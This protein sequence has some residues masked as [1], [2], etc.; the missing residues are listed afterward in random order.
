MTT[1]AAAPPPVACETV[2][3]TLRVRDLAASLA[4][5]VDRLGFRLGFTW[6]DPPDFAGVELDRVSIHL[7]LGQAAPEAGYV[8]FVVSDVDEL[9]RR[10]TAAGVSITSALADKPW[11]MREYGTEDPDGHRLRFGEHREQGPPLEIERV[12]VPVR[13]EKRLAALLVDLAAHKRFTVGEALEE[14]LLH[15][16]EPVAKDG[17]ASPHTVATLARIAELK[18]KHGVDYDTHASY[19]FVEK[20]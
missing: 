15:S 11:G 14:M 6:G 5:Y 9:H 7:G 13:L 4:F 12:D 18:R 2:H 17:V 1:A 10:H 20:P 19:R 3:P 8:Y 16:F